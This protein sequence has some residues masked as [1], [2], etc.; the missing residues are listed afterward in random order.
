METD[1][2]PTRAATWIQEF[3][4]AAEILSRAEEQRQRAHELV[5]MQR[6]WARLGGAAARLG[7]STALHRYARSGNAAMIRSTLKE[8]SGEYDWLDSTGAFPDNR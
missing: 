4:G 7:S 2:R 1:R 6:K 5:R 8:W 3:L